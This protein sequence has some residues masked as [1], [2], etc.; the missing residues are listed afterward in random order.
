MIN[1][2]VNKA[3]EIIKNKMNNKTDNKKENNTFTIIHY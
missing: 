2:L 1:L 3:D